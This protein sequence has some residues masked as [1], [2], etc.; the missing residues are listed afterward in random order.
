[1]TGNEA[2]QFKEWLMADGLLD[3]LKPFSHAACALPVSIDIQRK[4]NE[5]VRSFTAQWYGA[6]EQWPDDDWIVGEM[7]NGDYYF[8]SQSGSYSG[9]WQ[10]QHELRDKELLVLTLRD[11]YEWCIQ[12]E[13]DGGNLVS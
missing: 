13:K 3:K 4:L 10:Y 6:I 7:G 5:S 11:F 9:V 1:M 8:V 12:I 2:L